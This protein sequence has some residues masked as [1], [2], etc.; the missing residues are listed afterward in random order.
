M[1]KMIVLKNYF[2]P[3]VINK[4]RRLSCLHSGR[5]LVPSSPR[6]LTFGE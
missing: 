2:V 1:I 3:L 6:G 4:A 5:P